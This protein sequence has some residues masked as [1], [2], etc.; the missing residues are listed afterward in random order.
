MHKQ[1]IGHIGRTHTSESIRTFV[2]DVPAGAM[3]AISIADQRAKPKNYCRTQAPTAAANDDVPA[4]RNHTRHMHWSRAILPQKSQ[5]N[6]HAILYGVRHLYMVGRK[7]SR[8]GN[9]QA[10]SRGARSIAALRATTRRLAPRFSHL[11]VSIRDTNVWNKD[12]QWAI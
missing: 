9:Q 4:R 10:S 11:C 8:R 6:K 1:E 7:S 12:V 2:Y 5:W 3:H